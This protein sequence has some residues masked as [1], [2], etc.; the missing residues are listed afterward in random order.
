MVRKKGC[1]FCGV[2]DHVPGA[3]E[4]VKEKR[5]KEQSINYTEHQCLGLNQQSERETVGRV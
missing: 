5:E 1:L 2:D 4:P 3:G